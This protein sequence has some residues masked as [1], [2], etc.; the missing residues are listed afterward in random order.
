MQWRG[1]NKQVRQVAESGQ[2]RRVPD[3]VLSDCRRRAWMRME[4]GGKTAS[5]R[6]YAQVQAGGREAQGAR[7]RRTR[8]QGQ[9]ASVNRSGPEERGQGCAQ[10]VRSG[11]VQLSRRWLVV[12]RGGGRCDARQQDVWRRVGSGLGLIWGQAAG[13]REKEV[14][15]ASQR[16]V[17]KECAWSEGCSGDWEILGRKTGV[18]AN[19]ARRRGGVL[20]LLGVGTLR[21]ELGRSVESR[22]LGQWGGGRGVS[23]VAEAADS[24]MGAGRGTVR[25]QAGR[26]AGEAARGCADE[27][28]GGRRTGSAFSR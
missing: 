8:R 28:F 13:R 14:L 22:H 24:T 12:R 17:V 21:C 16:R 6:R 4:P 19:N 10:R 2:M 7:C 26:R 25:R 20:G 18:E 1:A 11:R 27:R 9:L 5:K 23:S 3:R 15:R